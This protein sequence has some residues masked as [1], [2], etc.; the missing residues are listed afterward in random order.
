M[1]DPG[2]QSGRSHAGWATGPESVLAAFDLARQQQVLRRRVIVADVVVL[3]LVW[4]AVLATA[5]P[6]RRLAVAGVGIGLTLAAV[7]AQGLYRA[8]AS[9]EPSVGV[10]PSAIAA[11][12]GLGGAVVAASVLDTADVS[13]S[14]LMAA[15][16]ASV[17]GLEL[18]RSILGAWLR[19][20]RAA[21]RFPRPIVLIGGNEEA[22][23][24]G[25]L[26][27]EHPELGFRVL[28]IV[29]P[30]DDVVPALA[31]EGVVWLGDYDDAV[32]VVNR[33]GVSEVVI[34]GTAVPYQRLQAL[35][36]DLPSTGVAVHLSAGVRGVAHR[37]M[38]WQTVAHEPLLSLQP[39]SPPGWQVAA[40]RSLDVF[41]AS[42]ALIAVSPLL[43]AA[44]VAIKLTDRGPVFFAQERVGQRGR[45]FRVLKLR[46]MVLD[47]DKMLADLRE[48]NERRDGPLFKLDHDPRVTRVGRFLRR[49]SIDE[50]P[51]L[52]NVLRGEMSL[53]GP[54][55]CL[56]A[57]SAL[58][59]EELRSRRLAARPGITGLWQI[60]ARDNPA[61]GAYRR[62]DLFYVDNW[63]IG[64]DLMILWTTAWRV[65]ERG[66]RALRPA[67]PMPANVSL[68]DAARTARAEQAV[69]TPDSPRRT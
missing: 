47:A 69:D 39:S 32:A 27:A 40:K 21:G 30:Y 64:L 5:P 10:M 53:V 60:E 41:V 44:A 66:L 34:A 8:R 3:T 6:G 31:D 58:F 14:R 11:A 61:F 49:T 9:A 15:A 63:T 51:Q 54:R 19:A 46:T 55:P 33:T 29:A 67:P 17:V 48:R 20:E 65:T 68:L 43:L 24:L 42:L 23:A 1:G 7:A 52:V 16:A 22:A 13:S 57:E 37:R 45:H 26:L 38:R 12:C 2:P 59:D 35:V 25:D 18:A 4:I 28:G 62:L 56:P 50:L 36:R